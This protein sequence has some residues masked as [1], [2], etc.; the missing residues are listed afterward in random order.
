MVHVKATTHFVRDVKK[1]CN[2]FQINA[3][4]TDKERGVLEPPKRE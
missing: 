3:T 4:Y 2:F 1:I